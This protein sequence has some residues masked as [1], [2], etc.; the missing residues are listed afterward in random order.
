[1]DHQKAH[2][3]LFVFAQNT[4]VLAKVQKRQKSVCLFTFVCLFMRYKKNLDKD[5]S[6]IQKGGVQ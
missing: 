2:R 3:Q 5:F 1:M 4:F 6:K